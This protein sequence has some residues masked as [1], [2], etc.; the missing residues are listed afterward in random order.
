VPAVANAFSLPNLDD[1]RQRFAV[2]SS[3]AATSRRRPV[4]RRL[5]PLHRPP[6]VA[7]TTGRPRRSPTGR[8]SGRRSGFRR[9]SR[10]AT[11]RSPPPRPTY[12]DQFNNRAVGGVKPEGEVRIRRTPVKGRFADGTPYTLQAPHY[13]L[14]RLAY[15]PMKKGTLLSPRVAPQLP[16]VGLLDA[17]AEAD[18]LANERAQAEAGG[19]IRGRANHVR[20]AWSGQTRIGRFGW[21]A[22]V[23]TLVHQTAGAFLGDMGITSRPFPHEACTARQADCLAS[24]SG[25]KSDAPEIDDTTL[26][27]VVFYESTL[28]PAARR[29]PRDAEV[30]QGQKLFQAA[31]CATC[32]RPSY[33]TGSA[34]FPALS[35]PK[36]AGD[37][38][39]TDLL[40]HDMGGG[41]PPPDGQITAANGRRRRWG[42]GLMR[43]QQPPALHDG[44]RWRARSGAVARRRGRGAT[45]KMSAAEQAAL[46]RFVGLGEARP[47]RAPR[48]RSGSGADRA[49]CSA[50][51][52]CRWPMRRPTLSSMA[53]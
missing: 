19:P 46:V 23:P 18:I 43:C 2:S 41:P 8:L 16:G 14:T 9:R 39:Y 15:G 12:G 24:P 35:T 20:D 52:R 34:P 3:F 32:H 7:A 40:V 30:L 44:R 29:S 36:V 6:W 1:E 27:H 11:T 45:A 51:R 33:V 25:A 28:A 17:I 4:A 47:S 42:R 10:P 50:E 21:K 38:P 31:Q 48:R 26:A 13:E 22:N 53:C 49:G 37:W 5:P